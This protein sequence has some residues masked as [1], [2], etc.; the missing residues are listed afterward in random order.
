MTPL[1]GY[2]RPVNVLLLA[3]WYVG[4][5]AGARSKGGGGGDSIGD[6]LASFDLP[7]IYTAAFAITIVIAV[8]T[9]YQ[10]V[11]AAL[12]FKAPVLPPDAPTLPYQVGKL[13]VPFLSLY[14]LVFLIYNIF[15]A[16]FVALTFS[17]S[18]SG[19]PSLGLVSG[20]S[21]VGQL[22][23]V[24]LLAMFLFIIAHR[25]RIQLNPAEKPF[26]IKSFLDSWLLSVVLILGI[27]SDA[28]AGVPTAGMAHQDANRNMN[29]AY[30]AFLFVAGLGMIVSS[31]VT[32]SRFRKSD[33]QDKV[34][35]TL[36]LSRV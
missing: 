9:L 23:K 31:I 35:F 12:R 11:R 15:Y 24:F 21:F 3:G 30:Q 2:L 17:L 36:L 14:T 25:E 16:V 1:L 5:A 27:A 33:I 19:L 18:N 10:M 32:Y 8:V 34:R 20:M 29:I 7:P 22:A 6:A 26:N 4:R 13:F 28:I